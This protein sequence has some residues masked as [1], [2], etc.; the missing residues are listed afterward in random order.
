MLVLAHL[1]ALDEHSGQLLRALHVG[2]RL[3]QA[4]G[5]LHQS[6]SAVGSGTNSEGVKFSVLA[7]GI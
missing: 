6:Q 5:E 7:S 1:Q 3:L 4:P 2:D